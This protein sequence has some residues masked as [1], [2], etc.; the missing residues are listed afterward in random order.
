MCTTRLA[1]LACASE[2]V[3]ITMVVPAFATPGQHL[4]HRI[5]VR[6]VEIAGGFVREDDLRIGDERPRHGH[7]LLLAA[8]ELL[9]HVLRAMREAH[10]LERHGDAPLALGGGHPPVDERHLHVLRDVQVVDE[11]EVLEHEADARAPAQRQLLFGAARD[12][13]AH[14]PVAAAR[15]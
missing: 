9:G 14:E 10:F 5:A 2:C 1:R 11:V 7:A 6:G 13:L 8:G 3:T 4:H 15:G 12:V